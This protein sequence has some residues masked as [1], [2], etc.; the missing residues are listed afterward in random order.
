MALVGMTFLWAPYASTPASE[1]ELSQ[2][3]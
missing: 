2:W 1:R 3:L